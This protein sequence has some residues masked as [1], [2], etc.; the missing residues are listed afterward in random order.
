MKSLN[1]DGKDRWNN[2]AVEDA[3]HAEEGSVGVD[4]DG[5]TLP[6]K[7]NVT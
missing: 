2:A 4:P 5:I 7:D 3:G 1:G 6:V